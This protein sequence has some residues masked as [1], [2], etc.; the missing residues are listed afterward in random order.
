MSDLF[1]RDL[2]AVSFPE[3]SVLTSPTEQLR[4]IP[5]QSINEHVD[6]LRVPLTVLKPLVESQNAPRL[7]TELRNAKAIWMYRRYD[8]VAVSNLRH[9]GM[10]NGV[11]NLRLLL[12]NDPPNWRGELV[13]NET[14]GLIERFFSSSMPPYDAAALFWWA[15]NMLFFQLGLNVR[16]DVLLCPY[17]VLV[18]DPA[19]TM[20][21]IYD[22]TGLSFPK[23][24]TGGAIYSEALKRGEGATLT[25]EVECAC[26][27]L[28]DRLNEC[29][30]EQGIRTKP[31]RRV[32][33]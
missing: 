8:S 33:V 10:H 18:S 20:R 14:R 1:D 15:R 11:R 5:S 17:E 13:P 26:S 9:F 21:G 4:L 22:F 16:D 28:Y 31:Q 3:E 6:R 12:T 27:V 2:R 30:A 7:L 32:P 24:D 29:F 25:P 23:R 19:E